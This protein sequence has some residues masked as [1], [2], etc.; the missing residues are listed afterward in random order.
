VDLLCYGPQRI[1]GIAG[2][3]AIAPGYDADFTIIDLKAE[4]TITNAWIASKPGWT[5][6]DGRKVKGWPVMTIVRGQLVMRE[7]EIVA[8]VPAGQPARFEE[9]LQ[10]QG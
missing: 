9:T 4:R 8:D 5:P 10:P 6:Y 2:K 3:G 1:Y 7:D